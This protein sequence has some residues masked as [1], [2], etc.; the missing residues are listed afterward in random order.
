MLP[1]IQVA[2]PPLCLLWFPGWDKFYAQVFWLIRW[3]ILFSLVHHF[4]P[5]TD[6]PLF[7][8][9]I[10]HHPVSK[11]LGASLISAALGSTPWPWG[12][13]VWCYTSWVASWCPTLGKVWGKDTLGTSLVSS[14]GFQSKSPLKCRV[15]VFVQSLP[16][17][18]WDSKGTVK[19]TSE[20]RVLF[21]TF[22]PI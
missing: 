18:R 21:L 8:F 16:L 3:L 12:P 11:R 17:L 1:P 4:P 15:M 9:E 22:K 19:D 14:G 13:R 2:H 10:N 6:L 20:S 7:R 5:V